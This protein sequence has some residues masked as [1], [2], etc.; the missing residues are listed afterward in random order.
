MMTDPVAD[1]LTRLRN[2]LANKS[3]TVRIPESKA[4][5]RLIE[6]LKREGYV[7]GFTTH[8]SKPTEGCGPQGWIEVELKYGSEDEQVITYL[9]RVSRS[10][11]RVYK[12]ARALR[13]VLN[14]LGI[15]ILST[16]RG[17]LSDR[18]ARAKGVGGEVLARVY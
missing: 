3:D 8:A 11:R 2:A 13:P 14:G 6:V 16:S 4:K 18:E 1:C 7:K 12:Q 10:G 15:D 5:I 17:V 9:Q